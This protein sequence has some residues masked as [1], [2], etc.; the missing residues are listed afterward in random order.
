MYFAIAFPIPQSRN[1][2]SVIDGTSAIAYNPYSAGAM[3]LAKIIDPTASMM[4]DAAFPM[5]S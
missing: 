5:K 3:S 1:R 4:V 2:L